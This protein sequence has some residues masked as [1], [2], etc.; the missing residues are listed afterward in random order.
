MVKLDDHA[1]SSVTDVKDEMYDAE[2]RRV[3]P[4]ESRIESRRC[5]EMRKRGI[6]GSG[7]PYTSSISARDLI[8]RSWER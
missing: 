2:S 6:E 3:K 5:K 7:V 4:R 1:N 8:V